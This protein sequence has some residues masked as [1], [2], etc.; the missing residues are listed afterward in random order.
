M[1]YF[2]EV[3]TITEVVKQSVRTAGNWLSLAAIG[4]QNEA[5]VN[6]LRLVRDFR[7]SLSKSR[8]ISRQ[9]MRPSFWTLIAAKGASVLGTCSRPDIR[10]EM[11]PKIGYPL[12]RLGSRMRGP[13]I[14][15]GRSAISWRSWGNRGQA[16]NP[17]GALSW[18]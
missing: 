17:R 14:F 9:L 6:A 5:P 11:D 12:P 2:P 16:A 1:V 8:A 7:E 15:N 18:P 10:L 3:R 4:V 13:L